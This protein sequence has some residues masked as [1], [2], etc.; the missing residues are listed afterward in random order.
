MHTASIDLSSRIWRKSFTGFGLVFGLFHRKIE[1]GLIH[2]AEC[3]DFHF[4]LPHREV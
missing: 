2:I 1:A 4:R 3:R